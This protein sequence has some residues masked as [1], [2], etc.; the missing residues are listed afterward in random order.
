[1]HT[2]W[3]GL[4]LPGMWASVVLTAFSYGFGV[5]QFLKAELADFI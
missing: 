1:M 5:R 3:G 2:P 4:Y